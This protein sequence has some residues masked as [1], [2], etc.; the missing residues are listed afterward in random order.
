VQKHSDS[1]TS[2]SAKIPAARSPNIHM[3]SFFGQLLF[4][5]GAFLLEN[6]TSVVVS[7]FSYFSL[8][9]NERVDVD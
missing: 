2:F 4:P 3:T 1:C 5:R 6:A 9:Q 8:K 7:N